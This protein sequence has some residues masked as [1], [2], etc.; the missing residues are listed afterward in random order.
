MIFPL[1]LLNWEVVYAGDASLH[2]SIFIKL[3]IFIAIGTEPMTGVVMP[4]VGEADGDSVAMK[5]PKFFD[6]PVI[7][8]L[9]PLSSEKLNDGFAARQ[10]HG[11]VAPNAI[12]SVGE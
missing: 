9:V 3:P 6:E 2:K 7:Q 12:L 11:A 5:R 1:G 8:F 10:E 4:L